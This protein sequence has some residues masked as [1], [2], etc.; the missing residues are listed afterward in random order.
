MNRYEKTA[1][2][3]GDSD[4]SLNENKQYKVEHKLDQVI[5]ILESIITHTPLQECEGVE[6][7][8]KMLEID[9]LLS[10]I[11]G[12]QLDEM[13]GLA[14]GAIG[15]IIAGV[16][17]MIGVLGVKAFLNHFEVDGKAIPTKV[18]N[19][20]YMISKFLKGDAERKEKLSKELK[21]KFPNIDGKVFDR[22]LET[23][24]KKDKAQEKENKDKAKVKFADWQNYDKKY[25]SPNLRDV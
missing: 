25:K 15:S 9:E 20:I 24:M 3:L 23:A 22:M 1:Y 11:R 2:L 12:T 10:N 7:A 19:L 17:S 18:A 13:D 5:E 8:D 6:F 4:V 14:L 21:A 16:G